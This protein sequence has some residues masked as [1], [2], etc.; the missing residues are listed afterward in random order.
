MLAELFFSSFLISWGYPEFFDEHKVKDEIGLISFISQRK[1]S[2][3]KR[4]I[5][6][7]T[8]GEFSFLKIFGLRADIPAG[9]TEKGDMKLSDISGVF[10]L[11]LP[12]FSPMPTF[13]ISFEFP[14]GSTPFTQNRIVIS[15]M[16][17]FRFDLLNLKF[18]LLGGARFSPSKDKKE[19]NV[20]YPHT[21]QNEVF[22]FLGG[23]TY[24]IPKILSFELKLGGI[25]E[26]LKKVVF[27]PQMHLNISIP[28]KPIEPKISLFGFGAIGQK[29]NIRQG[30]GVGA[31][32][33]VSFQ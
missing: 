12:D 2:N 33:S 20:L 13:L 5:L 32:A 6:I 11:S 18:S 7:G 28:T 29:S 4:N 3:Y 21:T 14:T 19:I 24:F 23:G 31:Y 16:V 8:F 25:Y 15:P 22:L 10:K 9:L 30:Y 27:Q 1:I 17:F 26:E